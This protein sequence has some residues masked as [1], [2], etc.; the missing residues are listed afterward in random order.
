VLALGFDAAWGWGVAAVGALVAAWAARGAQGGAADEA[1]RREQEAAARS[2]ELQAAIDRTAAELR[3]LMGE[4]RDLRLLRE[5]LEQGRAGLEEAR[6]AHAAARA[7]ATEAREAQERARQAAEIAGVRLERRLAEAGFD[8]VDALLAAAREVAAVRQELR[9]AE[10]ARKALLSGRTL[11][12]LDAEFGAL[13]A[14]RLGLQ[15][16][17]ATPELALVADID[18]PE[19]VHLSKRVTGLTEERQRVAS[20][21]AEARAAANH[22]EADPERLRSLEERQ[23]AAG[24]RLAALEERLAVLELAHELLAQ[25]HEETLA[26]AIDVLEPQTAALLAGLTCDRYERIE[27]DR[28]DLTPRVHSPEK[29]TWVT[30]DGKQPTELS[31]ATR[32]Q[33]YLAARLALTRLLW[34][35][36]LPP[37]M[38]DDPF[39]NF[40]PQ[41]RRHAVAVVRE[42]A[43]GAQVL[44]FTCDEDYDEFADRVIVLPGP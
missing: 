34:P 18:G 20:Q 37:I 24:E 12:E 19:H 23:A 3:A 9:D 40:D 33:V 43:T 1:R 35:E 28:T 16:E 27:F 17:L 36:D 41:R 25:A 13:N 42:L 8:S 44:L 38:L 21:I 11:E 14:D 29:G 32:E 15:A 7:A 39:V 5:R 6:Q 4:E 10:T 26:Q 31:C 30:L 22:P 2:D